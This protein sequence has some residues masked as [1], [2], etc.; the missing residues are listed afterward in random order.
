MQPKTSR[1]TSF[2]GIARLDLLPEAGRHLVFELGT[3]SIPSFVLPIVLYIKRGQPV[4]QPRDSVLCLSSPIVDRVS[5]EEDRGPTGP[6]EGGPGPESA[7][8]HSHLL[9]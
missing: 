1:G 4:V 7:Q 3:V 5:R 9:P 8:H 6:R 2:G